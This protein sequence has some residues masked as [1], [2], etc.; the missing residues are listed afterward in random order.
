MLRED[1]LICR[2]ECSRTFFWVDDTLKKTGIGKVRVGEHFRQRSESDGARMMISS[3]WLAVPF[4]CKE[5]RSQSLNQS[6]N[7]VVV[8]NNSNSCGVWRAHGVHH[9]IVPFPKVQ[10]EAV[11]EKVP[12]PSM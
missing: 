7:D 5:R 4:T 1:D 3:W 9:R 10:M 6:N 11:L 12:C 2:G 8:R